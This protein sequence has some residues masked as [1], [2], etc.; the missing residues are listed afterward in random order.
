MLTNAVQQQQVTLMVLDMKSV[1]MFKE[2]LALLPR[3]LAAMV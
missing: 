3:T 2:V 1:A